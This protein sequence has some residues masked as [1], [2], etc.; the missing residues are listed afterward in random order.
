MKVK[1]LPL[2]LL[3][4]FSTS[5]CALT[6][7]HDAIQKDNLQDASLD[8]ELKDVKPFLQR[9]KP[10]M[11]GGFSDTEI[12][13]VQSRIKK[14]KFNEEKEVGRFIV[15]YKNKKLFSKRLLLWEHFCKEPS[16]TS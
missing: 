6:P 13:Q 2:A 8:F 5:G 7:S 4:L 1:F 16:L 9:I 12:N 3:L 14:M 10:L 11:S 15:D